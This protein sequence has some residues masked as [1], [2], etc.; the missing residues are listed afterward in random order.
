MKVPRS[1]FWV[2][3][4]I[5]GGGRHGNGSIN[6]PKKLISF[7]EW[8][9]LSLPKKIFVGGE[10]NGDELSCRI[11]DRRIRRSVFGWCHDGSEKKRWT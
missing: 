4:V 10:F 9:N 8:K 2:G 1:I 6:I 11:S 3:G 5:D 7:K